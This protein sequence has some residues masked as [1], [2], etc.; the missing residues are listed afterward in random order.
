VP[1][2]KHVGL[3]ALVAGLII[4]TPGAGVGAPLSIDGWRHIDGPNELHVY[5]CDRADC[6]PGSTVVFRFGSPDAALAPG[7]LR[8]Q[9]AV[10]SAMLPE[11]PRPG[12]FSGVTVDVATGRT[13]NMATTSDGAKMYYASGMIHGSAW[14][15]FLTS[16]SSDEM[17]SEANLGRFKM[18]LNSA[19]K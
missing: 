14:Q 18:A 8:R 2:A 1:L 16:S 19:T 12:T 9:D 5:V 3:G 7:E 4:G 15:A 13:R 17:A 10:V 6:V 11:R